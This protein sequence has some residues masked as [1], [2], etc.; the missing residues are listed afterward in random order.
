ML[1]RAHPRLEVTAELAR[2]LKAALA[3]DVGTG[4][5]T[6][7]SIVPPA[8][9]GRG[10]I[11]AKAEGVL[12]GACIADH[13]WRLA[14]RKIEV[15][16]LAH[17]GDRVE[18]G[19]RVA[20]MKGPM[21]GLLTG[22][23]VALNFLQQLSGVATFTAKFHEAAGGSA[24]PLICDTRKTTP[25]WRRL[26]RYA[27]AVG[28]GCNHRFG[29]FDMV[30]IKEN[31]A[32][33]AGGLGEAIRRARKGAPGLRIAAEARDREEVRVCCEGHV[34]LI[35]LDNFTPAKARA[36]IDEF[37]S[38]GI[39]FEIS[40]GVTLKNIAAYA[41]AGADRISIGALTHSAPALDLSVQLY[42]VED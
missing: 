40:G 17:D 19:Q 23:R 41:K 38:T 9:Q 32:R 25:L 39:P 15:K 10:E 13:V 11:I 20:E 7:K 16:W 37:R 6:T 29:L 18:P 36:V 5:V 34:D 24:G 1:N 21:A 3:E 14:S 12:C 27:V 33:A 31:H 4:D 22:E 26:E 42:Q 30:L 35:L 28:G 2:L 8:L